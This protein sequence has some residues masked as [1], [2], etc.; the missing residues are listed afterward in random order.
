MRRP[1]PPIGPG[2]ILSTRNPRP[3]STAGPPIDPQ[4]L[5]KVDPWKKYGGRPPERAAHAP[6]HG[7]VPQLQPITVMVKAVGEAIVYTAEGVPIPNDRYVSVPISP[8]IVQAL[9]CGDLEEVE[10]EPIEQQEPTQ[11][12]DEAGAPAAVVPPTSEPEALPVRGRRRSL[13]RAIAT[14][15]RIE[16]YKEK[17]SCTYDQ[18]FEDLYQELLHASPKALKVFFHRCRKLLKGMDTTPTE[19]NA[20]RERLLSQLAPR[21]RRIVEDVMRDY[22]ALTARKTIEMLRAAGM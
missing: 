5:R 17:H 2:H 7:G 19:T 1:R 10:V 13:E 20:E 18:A 16:V 12:S 3:V 8:H 15:A 6:R 21:E 14:V 11:Q 9:R 22:P 4:K